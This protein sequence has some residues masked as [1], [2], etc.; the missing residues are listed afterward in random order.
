M[1]CLQN[2][3]LPQHNF[4]IEM[5]QIPGTAVAASRLRKVYNSLPGAERGSRFS[6]EAPVF[7]L[8]QDALG[9][10]VARAMCCAG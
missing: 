7:E 1:E 3:S 2:G 5:T 4:Q 6:V 8:C 9:S 10:Q